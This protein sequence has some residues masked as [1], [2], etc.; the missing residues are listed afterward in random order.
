MSKHHFLRFD[1]LAQLQSPKPTVFT[2]VAKAT[3]TARAA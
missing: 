3:E 2:F 1:A